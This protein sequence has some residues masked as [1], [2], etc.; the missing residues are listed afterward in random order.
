MLSGLPCCHA[1]SCI[2]DQKLEIDEFVPDYYKKECYAACY[3]PVIYP[4]NGES[5]WTK[6]DVVDLQP[7]PIKRQPGRPKKKRI[8]EVGEQMR[9]E[10]Q[11]KREKFGIKYSRCHKDDHNKAIC[12]LPT[13]STQPT[14]TDALIQPTLT[15]ASTHLTPIIASTHPSLFVASSHPIIA[16]THSSMPS[17]LSQSTPTTAS[18]HLSLPTSSS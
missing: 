4:V 13:T 18:T 16:S 11:L 10:S 2:K 15:V 3:A 14:P 9:N 12:K 17:A 1:I 6:I 5:L 7:S 8:K